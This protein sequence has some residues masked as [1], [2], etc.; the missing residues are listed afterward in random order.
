MDQHDHAEEL[1]RPWLGRY[2]G[3][4]EAAMRRFGATASPIDPTHDLASFED[5][6]SHSEEIVTQVM[7][8]SDTAD[9]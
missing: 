2:P 8:N 3:G 5:L 9:S 7:G 6:L 4:H 1:L